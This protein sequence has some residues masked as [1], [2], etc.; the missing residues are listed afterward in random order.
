MGSRAHKQIENIKNVRAALTIHHEGVPLSGCEHKAV[1][2]FGQATK[3]DLTACRTMPQLVRYRRFLRHQRQGYGELRGQGSYGDGT[4]PKFEDLRIEAAHKG[5]GKQTA[6]LE[7]IA[8]IAG[9]RPITF[10]G[11]LRLSAPLLC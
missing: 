11:A 10:D 9:I 1:H 4:F 6:A 8:V 5:N 3:G 7:Q 2:K